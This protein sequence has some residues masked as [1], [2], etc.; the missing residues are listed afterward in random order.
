MSMPNPP[1][2]STRARFLT[3][4]GIDRRHVNSKP[5]DIQ[6]EDGNVRI[7]W[8]GYMVVPALD[9]AEA[10]EISQEGDAPTL[11]PGLRE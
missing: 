10:I 8:G 1:T 3:A 4:L 9:F 6:F 5:L 7:S 2:K 11:L